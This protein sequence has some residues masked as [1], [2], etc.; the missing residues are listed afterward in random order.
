M[1]N[2]I[3]HPI[4]YVPGSLMIERSSDGRFTLTGNYQIGGTHPADHAQLIFE[5]LEIAAN[6]TD[7]FAPAFRAMCDEF[8]DLTLDW[9]D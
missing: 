1:T 3:S 2:V 8:M 7:K 5:A 9:A 6:S 4:V